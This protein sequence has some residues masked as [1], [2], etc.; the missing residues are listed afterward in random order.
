MSDREQAGPPGPRLWLWCPNGC[1]NWVE[2]IG[3]PGSDGAVLVVL[4]RET[5]WFCGVACAAT[6][7]DEMSRAVYERD[8]W[9]QFML[10]NTLSE[11]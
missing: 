7:M 8:G 1:G 6:C 5:F 10:F 3:A 2:N 11:N 4:G 9:P